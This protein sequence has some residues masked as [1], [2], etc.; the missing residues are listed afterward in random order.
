MNLKKIKKIDLTNKDYKKLKE[1]VDIEYE[2][3]EIILIDEEEWKDFE[4][5][6]ES[7]YFAF[8]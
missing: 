2:N 6:E 5:T 1:L 4:L 3:D 7:K 8:L